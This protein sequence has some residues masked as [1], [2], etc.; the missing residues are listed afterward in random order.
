LL[1]IQ[2]R[3][4]F[5]MQVNESRAASAKPPQA[6]HQLPLLVHIKLQHEEI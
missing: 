3:L 2:A 1:T 6:L 5:S 4:L